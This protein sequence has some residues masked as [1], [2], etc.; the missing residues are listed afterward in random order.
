MI[1]LSLQMD[2]RLLINVMNFD[3]FFLHISNSLI[4]V[5]NNLQ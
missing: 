3:D 2:D 1:R 5:V 4:L